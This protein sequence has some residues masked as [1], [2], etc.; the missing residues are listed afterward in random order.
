M[1]LPEGYAAWHHASLEEV[2]SCEVIF[3]GFQHL[4]YHLTM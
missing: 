4:S 1:P 2:N 3:A